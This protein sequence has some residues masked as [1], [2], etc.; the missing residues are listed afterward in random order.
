MLNS[1]IP[2]IA[3]PRQGEH[4]DPFVIPDTETHEVLESIY[5]SYSKLVEVLVGSSISPTNAK[6]KERKR[7]ERGEK[8]AEGNWLNIKYYLYRILLP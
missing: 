3:L 4:W 8:K 1:I 2:L 7:K 5:L 6:E